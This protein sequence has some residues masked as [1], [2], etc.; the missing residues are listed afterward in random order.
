M[1]PPAF[2]LGD[3]HYVLSEK[4]GSYRHFPHQHPQEAHAVQVGQDTPRAA[5]SVS[6]VTHSLSST[7]FQHPQCE[8]T[9]TKCLTVTSPEKFAGK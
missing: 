3:D 6:E 1:T 9:R 8:G 4:A 5:S 2:D 7:P